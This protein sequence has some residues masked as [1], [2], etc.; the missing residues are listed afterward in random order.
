MYFGSQFRAQFVASPIV[1]G[2]GENVFL[3]LASNVKEENF[4]Q[5]SITSDEYNGRTQQHDL[6]NKQCF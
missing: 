5:W 2:V 1:R 6:S 4:V 3:G